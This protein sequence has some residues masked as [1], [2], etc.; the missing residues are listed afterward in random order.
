MERPEP[1]AEGVGAGSPPPHVIGGTRG[2]GNV[3]LC[4]TC[5]AILLFGKVARVVVLLCP[6]GTRLECIL[7]ACAALI[8]SSGV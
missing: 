1:R 4:Y 5:E 8:V 2:L 3:D 6:G 7:A